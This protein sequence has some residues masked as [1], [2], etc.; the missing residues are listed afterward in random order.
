MT[1]DID[2]VLE[3]ANITHDDK[4][5]RRLNTAPDKIADITLKEIE[6]GIT[7]ERLE[8]LNVPVYQYGTQ[9]TIHGIF[10]NIPDDLYVAGY[11]SVVL[12]GNKSL[13]VKY[14]AIDGGKKQL[15]CEVSRYAQD[16]HWHISIDSKGCTAFKAF[17]SA[18]R[19]DDLKRAKECYNSTPDDLYIGYK[20]VG[21]L[22][23]GYGYGILLHIGA[24]YERNLWPLIGALT[25]IK[26]QTEYEQI[27]TE[28]ERQRAIEHAEYE[29]RYQLEQERKRQE[30]DKAFREFQPPS[31][32]ISYSGKT[33]D[34]G[35]YARI[36]MDYG[37]RM[38][39]QGIKV[40]KRGAYLCAAIRDFTDFKYTDWTP[41]HYHKT[42]FKIENGWIIPF[43]NK[44]STKQANSKIKQDDDKS[45]IT[46]THNTDK[47]GI[48]VSFKTKPSDTILDVL[49]SN[50][51]RWS[52]KNM[53]WYAPYSP[54]LMTKIQSE[55]IQPVLA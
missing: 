2:T 24:I 15:L 45:D 16:R 3:S 20:E 25:G 34:I 31:N 40:V 44:Q 21:S 27:K 38:T 13:G 46:I 10:N 4:S 29:R 43:D 42:T 47:N 32:W 50:G 1:T 48:E 33:T 9:I 55:L 12:N 35:T 7:I 22:I 14:V 52:Y 36:H 41:T 19:D 6:Q 39:L 53:L 18:N 28:Y 11:K 26:S 5:R 8:S 51:F 37:D 23:L 49:R 17:M 30:L 54:K